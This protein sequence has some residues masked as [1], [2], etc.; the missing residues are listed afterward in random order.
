[1][2]GEGA[3]FGGNN[4][5]GEEVIHDVVG[6]M[7]QEELLNI[8]DGGHKSYQQQSHRN[9]NLDDANYDNDQ[10]GCNGSESHGEQQ[11]YEHSLCKGVFAA[12][13]SVSTLQNHRMVPII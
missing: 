2:N 11:H 1:M 7:A 9:S 13:R 12:Y 4:T 6:R 3:N 8:L 10:D 5:S